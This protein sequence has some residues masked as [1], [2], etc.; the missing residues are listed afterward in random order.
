[1]ARIAAQLPIRRRAVLL[2][3]YLLVLWGITASG[4]FLPNL[5]RQDKFDD[6][7]QQ[8]VWWAYQFANPALF[9]HD[10]MLRFMSGP[11]CAPPGYKAMYQLFAPYFDAQ[12]FSESIPFVLSL[13]L[14]GTALL[15]GRQV[16]GSW[17]AGI[18]MA[19]VV[20]DRFYFD[21]L[22]GGFPRSWGLLIMLFAM[23]ALIARRLAL[24]GAAL[25]AAGLFYPPAIPTPAMCAVVVLG[26]DLLKTRKMPR[27]WIPCGVLSVAAVVMMLIVMKGLPPEFGP[28]VTADQARHMPEFQPD[29][30]AEYFGVGWKTFIFDSPLSGFGQPMSE[31]LTFAAAVLLSVVIFG[32]FLPREGWLLLVGSLLSFIAAHL[33][34]FH[35]HVPNRH[36]QYPLVV[37]R[38]IWLAALA[39]PL[40]AL[41]SRL[42]D[43]WPAL[44]GRRSLTVTVVLVLVMIDF[45]A[46]SSRRLHKEMAKPVDQDRE[47]AIAFIRSLPPDVL[48]AA[49]PYDGDFI[50]LRT[51]HSV[52]A[53]WETYHPYWMGWYHYIQPRV[54]AE[55][56]ATYASDWSEVAGLHVK[57]GVGV[58]LVNADRYKDEKSIWFCRPYTADDVERAEI[59]RNK[60]FA[61]LNP[62]PDRVLYRSG[63]FSVVRLSP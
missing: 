9:P 3:I 4:R 56:K 60:G 26:L 51:Q 18:I 61:L 49:H 27:G 17:A 23:W 62:P 6:D 39:K 24:L 14:M 1:M 35:M 33:L 11:P 63:R 37:F 25:F 55:I 40:L 5:V 32:N 41:A 21:H 36:V 47:N 38:I 30:R 16:G 53:G 8:H 44:S 12:R 45:A 19:I 2:T 22:M 58:F 13:L 46:N 43:R 15:L 31:V 10:E 50:P 20:T 59:G 52:L 42:L 48:V 34:L 28:V 7:A 57:Y 54:E 29:A